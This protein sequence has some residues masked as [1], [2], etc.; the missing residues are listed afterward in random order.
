MGASPHMQPRTC[1]CFLNSRSW[2]RASWIEASIPRHIKSCFEG[3]ISES[4]SGQG[5][6]TWRKRED[7]AEKGDPKKG[8]LVLF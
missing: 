7:D 1:M 2:I 3:M 6:R 4:E 5:D 8:K